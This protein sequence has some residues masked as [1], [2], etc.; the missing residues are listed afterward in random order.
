MRTAIPANVAFWRKL[1]LDEGRGIKGAVEFVLASRGPDE[2]IVAL[3]VN[4]YFPAKYYVGSRARIALL[5]PGPDLFWG[6]HLIRSDDLIA[7]D[8]LD[9]EINRGVWLI[10][11][12]STPAI[13]P[14][15]VSAKPRDQQVFTYYNHLHSR[16]FVHHYR[17]DEATRP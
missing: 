6:W 11:T 16:V 3:D 9:R 15:L 8:Q 2:T 4:Q 17:T 5:E 7:P 1:N 13:T 10:G 14:G 12:L